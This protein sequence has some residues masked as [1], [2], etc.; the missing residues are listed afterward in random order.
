MLLRCVES[1]FLNFSLLLSMFMNMF[2]YSVRVV[3]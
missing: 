1:F 2:V 3:E